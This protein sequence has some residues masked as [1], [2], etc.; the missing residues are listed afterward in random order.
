VYI[1]NMKKILYAIFV[2]FSIV[3]SVGVVIGALAYENKYCGYAILVLM[4]F[5][6]ISKLCEEIAS[7][8]EKKRK[9]LLN[10]L[11]AIERAIRSLNK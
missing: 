3:T 1:G 6:A 7:Y 9:E 2:I 5:T 4:A 10:R 11:D 8:R